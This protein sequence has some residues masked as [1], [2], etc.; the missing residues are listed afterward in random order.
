MR[1]A[2]RYSGAIELRSTSLTTVLKLAPVAFIRRSTSVATSGSRVVVVRINPFIDRGIN[3]SILTTPVGP[4]L[5]QNGPMS[6]APGAPSPIASLPNL[7][8]LGG[9]STTDGRRVRHGVLYRSTDFQS[10]ATVDLPPFRGLDIRTIYDLRSA[11]ERQARPDPALPEVTDVP[12]DILADATM[13][14]PAN[15]NTFLSDP[16]TVALATKELSGGKARELIAA[17][18]RDLVSL[19]SAITGYQFFYRGLLGEYEQPA[20]FHCTTGKDRTGWAAATFLSL[21]GVPR[22]DIYHDYLLTNDRLVPALKPVFDQFAAAGG[23]PQL[24]T[25]V[26]GVDASYLE[27]AFAEMT[28][29]Y[30]GIEG[31][32]ADGLGIGPDEQQ[33]LRS[34]YL[35]G[36]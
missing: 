14:I 22:D 16:A 8:D 35:D 9:W 15:L 31:Y 25:P 28:S 1:N 24:L 10:L 32:F 5:G 36:V 26:L 18:Y 20:L 27:A 4:G 30:G 2:S 33:E 19:P 7:R 17:T 11:A 23:D 13:A 29:T 3:A 6:V 21:M 12:L 34:Q